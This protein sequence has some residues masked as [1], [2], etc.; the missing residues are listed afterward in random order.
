MEDSQLRPQ[1]RLRTLM[2]VIAILAPIFAVWAVLADMERTFYQFYQPGGTLE[3][4]R[5]A[6]H[7]SCGA[8]HLASGQFVQAES[9]FLSS[10]RSLRGPRRDD[11]LA[12]RAFAGLGCALV[13]QGRLA[14]AE[15]P[16]RSALAIRERINEP[17]DPDLE[18]VLEAHVAALRA[19]GHVAEAEIQSARAATIRDGRAGARPGQSP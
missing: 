8:T 17:G 15:A 1:L 3:H 13:A 14:E 18:A 10:L 7:A 9:E 11:L 16:L 12:A 4:D 19:A 6:V 5:A 2:I